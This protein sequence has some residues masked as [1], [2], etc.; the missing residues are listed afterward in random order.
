[1]KKIFNFAKIWTIPKIHNRV[2][3]TI[4]S[5]AMK[6]LENIFNEL[7]TRIESGKISSEWCDNFA[8]GYPD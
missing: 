2:G 1:L 6:Q 5:T 3:T 8:Q 4:N 7:E